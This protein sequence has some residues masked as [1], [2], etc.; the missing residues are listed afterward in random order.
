MAEETVGVGDKDGEEGGEGPDHEGG[1]EVRQEGRQVGEGM[2]RGRRV[3]R[4]LPAKQEQS[5]LLYFG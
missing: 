1:Q 4:H 3:E 2:T 5:F